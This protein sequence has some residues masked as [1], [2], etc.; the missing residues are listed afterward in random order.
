MSAA[1]PIA[2]LLLAIP[3]QAGA[4]EAPRTDPELGSP[5]EDVYGIPLEEARRDAAPGPFPGSA[6]RSENAYGSSEEVPGQERTHGGRED[7]GGEGPGAGGGARRIEG[8]Q[9][10]ARLS[11]D[12]SPV[13]TG[14]LL[15]LIVATAAAGGALAA[16]LAGRRAGP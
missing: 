15:A 2:A 5:S 12:P 9:A 8:A 6:I 10:A 1:V 16:R 3:A 13:A 7:P 11:G 4:Q 14:L